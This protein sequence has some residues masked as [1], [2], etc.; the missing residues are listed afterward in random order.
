[1]KAGWN[2]DSTK[3][4]TIVTVEYR[5]KSGSGAFIHSIDQI[6]T[7]QKIVN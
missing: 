6:K 4:H 5:T 7:T 3:F 1:M 2:F